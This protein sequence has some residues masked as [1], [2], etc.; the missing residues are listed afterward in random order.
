[1]QVYGPACVLSVLVCLQCLCLKI[2]FTKINTGKGHSHVYD[3]LEHLR[4]VCD[5]TESVNV[6]EVLL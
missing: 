5:N 3:P 6:T 1:M 4:R 2:I